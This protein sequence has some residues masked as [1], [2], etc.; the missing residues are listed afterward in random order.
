MMN[1]DFRAC[2][3]DWWSKIC[4]NVESTFKHY[5]NVIATSVR[6]W[7]NVGRMSVWCCFTMVG[8]SWL[9]CICCRRS[10]TPLLKSESCPA[11]EPSTEA[12]EYLVLF[13]D[14]IKYFN[15]KYFLFCS[16]N[17]LCFGT[18]KYITSFWGF[19]TLFDPVC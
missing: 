14:S 16:I 17:K 13:F 10:T 8:G 5:F 18:K 6:H 12:S 4:S 15:T 2:E 9:Q 11:S 19:G 3:K 7:T 1:G